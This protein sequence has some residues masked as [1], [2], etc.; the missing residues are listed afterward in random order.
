MVTLRSRR[1]PAARSTRSAL[2]AQ[3]GVGWGRGCRG[4]SGAGGARCACWAPPKAEAR[5]AGSRVPSQGPNC[6]RQASAGRAG[7]SLLRTWP[8]PLPTPPL[9]APAPCCRDGSPQVQPLGSLTRPAPPGSGQ[10]PCRPSRRPPAA[11]A[12]SRRLSPPSRAAAARAGRRPRCSRRARRL[13]RRGPC[14]Q[15]LLN[16]KGQ[17]VHG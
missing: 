16:C 11:A 9:L 3:A 10:R 13:H 14:G 15:Q 12:S 2:C 5:G 17:G 1:H 8:S 7:A 4:A 6:R